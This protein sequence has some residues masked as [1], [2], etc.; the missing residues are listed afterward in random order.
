MVGNHVWQ[1]ESGDV[2]DII[3][4]GFELIEEIR[5]HELRT[6]KEYPWSVD[7]NFQ[8]DLNAAPV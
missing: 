1:F 5:F 8:P 4:N 3:F 2:I 6:V 7:T